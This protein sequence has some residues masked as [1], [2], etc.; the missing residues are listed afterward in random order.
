MKRSDLEK[1]VDIAQQSSCL[2][3]TNL[4][5]AAQMIQS[6]KQVAVDQSSES[7]R[8]FKLKAYLEEVLLQLSPKL[9][10]SKHTVEVKGDPY[11]TLN[12]YP[13]TFSQ[14][15][16]NLVMNSIASCLSARSTGTHHVNV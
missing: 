9:K 8:V 12:S 4:E 13:G 6:F 10:V 3:L 15:V 14:I 2:T 1:F 16:T 7:K 5:R 11:L